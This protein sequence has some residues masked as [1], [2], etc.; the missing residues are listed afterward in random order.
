MFPAGL[1]GSPCVPINTALARTIPIAPPRGGSKED[2]PLFVG[3]KP[4]RRTAEQGTAEQPPAEGLPSSPPPPAIVV[5]QD[6]HVSTIT[7]IV[8]VLL[9]LTVVG[10]AV[11]F[12]V[13]RRRHLVTA[14]AIADA[15][16]GAPPAAAPPG[17]SRSPPPPAGTTAPSESGSTGWSGWQGKLVRRPLTSCSVLNRCITWLPVIGARLHSAIRRYYSAARVRD[18]IMYMRLPR[19]L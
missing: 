3:G 9:L 7:S 16:P 1:P 4:D 2:T 18:T 10:L 11:A 5:T 14:A 8:L 6:S 19:V 17:T 12:Y 13:T 15:E